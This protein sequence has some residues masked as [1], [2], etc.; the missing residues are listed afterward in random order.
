MEIKVEDSKMLEFDERVDKASKILLLCHRKPDG[1]AIGTTIAVHL[2]L[3]AKGK[4]VVSCSIDP[5]SSNYHFLPSVYLM[6]RHFGKLDLYDLIIFLDC[7][8]KTITNYHLEHKDL[9][10]GKYPIINID[11]HISNDNFGD[12][13]I[14]LPSAASTSHI[15]YKM[16]KKSGV[17]ITTDIATLLLA[18]LYYDTGSFKH[19]NTSVEVLTIASKLTQIGAKADSIARNMFNNHS[20]Q[21]LKAW[22]KILSRIK[23]NDKKIISSILKAK[24]LEEIGI[25]MNNLHL[26]EVM[27][28]LDSIPDTKFSVLLAESKGFIKGSF[29]TSNN[30]IDV[31]KIAKIFNGG[32]HKKAA[33]FVINGEINDIAGKLR[34]E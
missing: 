11:H 30:N 7:G 4:E 9:F 27:H 15:V 13:N 1:D 23:K 33:G 34:I 12:L 21:T 29:R 28:Y 16:F 2:A 6:R 3:R 8:D 32:G 31:S 22:G 20:V 26:A 10:S 14:V 17:K 25:D 24:D 19:D 5:V 18:G